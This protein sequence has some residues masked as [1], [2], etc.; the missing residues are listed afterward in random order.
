MILIGFI[1]LYEAMYFQDYFV[2]DANIAMMFDFL[3]KLINVNHSNLNPFHKLPSQ[4]LTKQSI[5]FVNVQ[6]HPY[7]SFYP[8]L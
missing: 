7:L 2:Y 8:Q 6:F 5:F 3:F 4:H 1:N